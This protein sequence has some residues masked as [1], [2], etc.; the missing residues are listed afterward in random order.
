VAKLRY[1]AMRINAELKAKLQALANQEERTL[2]N[3]VET[4]LC[5]IAS[6]GEATR[7]RA[8]T[9]RAR[10]MLLKVLSNRHQR[11]SR[12]TMRIQTEL[13][14]AL[15]KLADSKHVTLTDFIE[16]ELYLSVRAASPSSNTQQ[17][18]RGR[19]AKL[20]V[21]VTPDLKRQLQEIADRQNRKLSDFIK[22]QLHKIEARTVCGEILK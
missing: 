5:Q 18:A 6:V 20:M 7:N 16:A 2:T 21:Y 13:K 12:L 4:R 10:K 17:R 8:S 1:L 3:F 22:V 11:T 15:Q 9:A 14:A 19:T